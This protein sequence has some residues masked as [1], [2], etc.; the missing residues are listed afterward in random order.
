[1]SANYFPL[2]GVKPALGRFFRPEEDAVPDRDRVAVIGFALWT[3]WFDSAAT[4]L[5]EI[6]KIN[7]VPFTIVGVA[8]KG[9]YGSHVNQSEI[10]IP[11]MMLR[12]GYR[13]CTDSLAEDCTILSM[14]GRLAAG[15]TVDEAKA[16]I[17]T[18][19]PPRWTPARPG[20]NSGLTVRS[21]RG[22]DPSRTNVLLVN[23]LLLVAVVLLAVSS[24]NLAGLLLAR[25]TARSSRLRFGRH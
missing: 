25:G 15:R 24:A 1:M 4:V 9:F 14:T 18:L 11:T 5:G 20:D 10:Y 16:E 22:I 2:L 6:V 17:A 19:V 13:W 12:T 7:G 21:E 8:P 23:L 3:Q